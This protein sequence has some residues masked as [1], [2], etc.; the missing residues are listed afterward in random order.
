MNKIEAMLN[1]AKIN[2]LLHKKD[3]EAAIKAA[4]KKKCMCVLGFIGAVLLASV[5]VYVVYRYITAKRL[6]DFEDF[7]DFEEEFEDFEE[8]LKETVDAE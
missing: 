6:D 3:K 7:E 8:E 1:T 4:K 2:E 5:I